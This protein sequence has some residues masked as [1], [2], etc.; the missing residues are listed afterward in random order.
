M[1]STPEQENTPSFKDVLI[2]RERNL[3]RHYTGGSIDNATM[4]FQV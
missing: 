2:C 3:S 4:L 1:Y